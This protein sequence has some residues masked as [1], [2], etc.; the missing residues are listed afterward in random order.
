MASSEAGKTQH[1]AGRF[2]QESQ[3][4]ETQAH[5]SQPYESRAHETRASQQAGRSPAVATVDAPA[6]GQR[7]DVDGRKLVVYRSGS[8]GPAVVFLPGAGRVGLDYLNIHNEISSFTT[9]VLYDRGG[10]GWSDQ[11]ELPRSA[12]EVAS[13]LRTLLRTAGVPAPYVLVGHSLGG[14]YARRYAQLYPEEVAGVLFLEAFVD[15]FGELKLKKTAGGRL[16]QIFA[17]LRLLTHLRSFYRGMFE[18]QF[19]QWPEP[20]R[21]QLIEYHLKSLRNTMK[22]RKNIFTEVE[23]EIRDG[24]DMPDV[25]V[26][27]VAA[28]GIDPFQAVLLPEAQLRELNSRK[29]ALYAPLVA[30]VPRGEYRTVD[31]AGHDTIW[32]DRPDAVI[33]AIRDLLSNVGG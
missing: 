10:T 2:P 7:Y 14:A 5:E 23:A 3:P 33:G 29:A 15:G 8:G 9:S 12:E 19:A 20:A 25:P 17:V 30:S 28:T 24:G 4:H 16:W 21:G 32:T 26:T 6:G 11:A 27:V 18:Q 1:E 31:G 22:E 13:E